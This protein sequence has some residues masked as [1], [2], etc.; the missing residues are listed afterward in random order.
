MAA[1][2]HKHAG[3][4]GTGRI[5][6]QAAAPTAAGADF[7]TIAI[8]GLLTTIVEVRRYLERCD[9]YV[10]GRGEQLTPMEVSRANLRVDGSLAA[11]LTAAGGAE[12]I[13]AEAELGAQLQAVLQDAGE[14][15]HATTR[16]LCGTGDWPTADVYQTALDVLALAVETA[17]PNS[18]DD[19]HDGR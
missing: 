17:C 5:E 12:T 19:P 2:T 9:R 8:A 6:A 7:G 4:G 13:G 16:A 1:T 15:C 10:R 11:R 18:E 14:L 3:P